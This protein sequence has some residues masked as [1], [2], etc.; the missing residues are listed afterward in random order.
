MCAYSYSSHV[1]AARHIHFHLAGETTRDVCHPWIHVSTADSR[2]F[3][4][5]AQMKKKQAASPPKQAIPA[6]VAKS[7]ELLRPSTHRISTSA[8]R[9][10]H[11]HSST[12]ASNDART[13]NCT[14]YP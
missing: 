3:Y 5:A 10:S 4:I 9:I 2:H 13:R 11:Q 14:Q 1:F 12:T 6:A 7:R 8:S